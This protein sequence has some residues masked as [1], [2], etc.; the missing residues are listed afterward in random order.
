MTTAHFDHS[1]CELEPFVNQ[2]LPFWWQLNHNVRLF[3]HRGYLFAGQFYVAIVA[4]VC[5][6]C[7]FVDEFSVFISV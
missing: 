6:V 1:G 5:T 7:D 2:N 4:F 3:N